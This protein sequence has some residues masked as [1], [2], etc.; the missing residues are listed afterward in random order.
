[1]AIAAIIGSALLF[2]LAHSWYGRA[3]YL[4]IPFVLGSVWGTAVHV[5]GSLW[6]GVVLHGVWNGAAMLVVKFAPGSA[7]TLA[8]PDSTAEILIYALVALAGLATLGWAL[9]HARR[10]PGR[11]H[12]LARR[13]P[14]TA[15]DPD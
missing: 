15:A 7:A 1:G 10:R 8:L 2:A 12:G 5:T 6:A 11:P 3:E 9:R 4:L 13:R 14:G